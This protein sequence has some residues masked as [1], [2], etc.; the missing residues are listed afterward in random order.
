MI[1]S[2]LGKKINMNLFIPIILNI[3]T[4]KYQ[5]INLFLKEY[6]TIMLAMQILGDLKKYIFRQLCFNV[7]FRLL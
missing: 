3:F 5:L 6:F 7:E 2:L 1:S 4:F